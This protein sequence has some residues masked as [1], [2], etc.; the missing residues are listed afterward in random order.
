M[1][2][3]EKIRMNEGLVQSLILIFTNSFVCSTSK[4]LAFMSVVV[5][6]DWADFWGKN[7]A[8]RAEEELPEDMIS[9]TVF[10][11]GSCLV[12]ERLAFLVRMGIVLC[13]VLL[14]TCWSLGPL[15][16][17]GKKTVLLLVFWLIASSH[18]GYELFINIAPFLG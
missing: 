11:S 17:S 4:V 13:A 10:E 6:F 16:P 7:Q 18:L 9:D 15:L 2:G 3:T 12:L 1:V 5:S 8:P 14:R